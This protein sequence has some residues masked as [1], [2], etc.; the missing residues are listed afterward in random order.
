[1][2]VV[3]AVAPE[4]GRSDRQRRGGGRP[5]ELRGQ[6]AVVPAQDRAGRGLEQHHVLRRHPRRGPQEHAAWLVRQLGR[7][8][9][10]DQFLQPVVQFIGRTGVVQEDQVRHQPAATPVGV[11]AEEFAGQVKLVGAGESGQHDRQV[12]GDGVWP[13][14]RL[15]EAV[16]RDGLSRPQG[17]PGEENVSGQPLEPSGVFGCDAERGQGGLVVDPRLLER[18]RYFGQVAEPAGQGHRLV[19]VGDRCGAEGKDGG[20]ARGEPDPAAQAENG[21]QD[22]PDGP[23]QGNSG[24]QSGGAS[25]GAAPAQE[26]GPV[27]L[28]L[29]LSDRGAGGALRA[30]Q[31][32]QGP[33]RLLIPGA[34]PAAAQQGGWGGQVF[35]LQ[36][37]LGERRMSL[38]GAAVVEGHL[39]V[40]GH[41]Q[42]AGLGRRGWST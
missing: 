42:R 6:R 41:L 14:A 28:V 16:S 33:D 25:R 5:L 40:A 11:G 35:G 17:R 9:Q 39:R 21:V 18:A 29:D 20:C 24:I 3:A 23:R 8:S 4:T 13:Q 22:R 10:P 38:V 19:A 2:P 36:E 12:S 34:R 15:A 1:M 30:R 7:R 37:K 26:S 32:V 31:D 27:G